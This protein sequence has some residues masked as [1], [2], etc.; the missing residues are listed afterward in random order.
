MS[1]SFWRGAQWSVP[2]L[3]AAGCASNPAATQHAPPAP[4]PGTEACIFTVNL[5][6]WTVLDSST[7]IVYAPMRRDPFLVKLFEPIFDLQFRQ[8]LGFEDTEHNG[9]LC[10]GDYVV[11]R[12]DA[13]QRTIISAVRALTPEQ[14][15]QMVAAAKQADAAK[16]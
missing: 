8:T 4:L 12:G 5:N 15:K 16:K 13:P 14:A 11:A 7:L 2:L 9:Q 1:F 3:L 10:Q 6:D